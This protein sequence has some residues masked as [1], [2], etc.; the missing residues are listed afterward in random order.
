MKL[1]LLGAVALGTAALAGGAPRA[2]AT[3]NDAAA[4]Y[5]TKPGVRTHY[6][7]NIAFFSAHIYCGDWKG[8]VQ[9]QIGTQGVPVYRATKLV[10]ERATSTDVSFTVSGSKLPVTGK[11]EYTMKVGRHDHD[12]NV[13]RWT[14]SLHGL[15]TKY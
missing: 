1:K 2:Q 4:P 6:A 7:G 3:T 13:T 8:I 12:G 5:I 10:C 15:F 11:Y 14:H 9:L